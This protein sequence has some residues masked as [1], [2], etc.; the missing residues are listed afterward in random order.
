[1]CI[2]K[3][4]IYPLF[5][6]ALD[7]CPGRQHRDLAHPATPSSRQLAHVWCIW[8][9]FR[10]FL[11]YIFHKYT[12]T[13]L[14]EHQTLYPPRRAL[15]AL[16][17]LVYDM[18]S[19]SW[20]VI[21]ET[22]HWWNLGRG[23]NTPPPLPGRKFYQKSLLQPLFR[24]PFRTEWWTKVIMSCIP[25]SKISRSAYAMWFIIQSRQTSFWKG[26]KN[27]IFLFYWFGSCFDRKDQHV[28]TWSD[29]NQRY[30][31]RS[32]TGPRKQEHFDKDK[33]TLAFGFESGL[34]KIEMGL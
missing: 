12:C 15:Y 6:P 16:T 1:M 4:N 33:C 11:V 27:E 22:I 26:V 31:I 14:T 29:K 20:S 24:I 30:I 21:L 23:C 9:L 17:L 7:W 18:G 2:T 32:L 34:T 8:V 10:M 5:L 25:L 13:K 19:A 3:S 28:L